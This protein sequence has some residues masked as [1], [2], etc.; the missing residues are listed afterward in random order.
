MDHC[1]TA[2]HAAR[3]RRPEPHGAHL[4]SPHA[5]ITQNEKL[6]L[7]VNVESKD[8]K[9]QSFSDFAPHKTA[10]LYATHHLTRL[11][12]IVRSTHVTAHRLATCDRARPAT[13]PRLHRAQAA[14]VH[15]AH[16][17]PKAP[18]SLCTRHEP[19]RR[20]GTAGGGQHTRVRGRRL[21]RHSREATS[22]AA[23]DAHASMGSSRMSSAHCAIERC[24]H[25][26][27]GPAMRALQV[28][29]IRRGFLR[30][31]PTN[32]SRTG[33]I[34]TGPGTIGS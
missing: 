10:P 21:H 14:P 33:T 17:P 29:Q 2:P 15:R 5:H 31:P 25:R 30:R 12:T 1:Y 22:C 34:C 20:R 11:V 24:A 16:G 26:V 32:R 23:P 3:G 18:P 19:L 7:V 6:R 28:Q 13:A 4:S 9:R 8:I 27:D